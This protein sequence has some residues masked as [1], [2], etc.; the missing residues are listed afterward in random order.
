MEGDGRSLKVL[1][2]TQSQRASFLQILMRFG[3]EG[4]KLS[5]FELNQALLVI[6]LCLP[7]KAVDLC[8]ICVMSFLFGRSSTSSISCWI[9]IT[10]NI[11]F[12][13]IILAVG[14]SAFLDEQNF[15]SNVV[16]FRFPLPKAFCFQLF[17]LGICLL[18][19]PPSS[20]SLLN[21]SQKI[22]SLFLI[23]HC[24]LNFINV[25]Q[26]YHISLLHLWKT[27]ILNNLIVFTTWNPNWSTSLVLIASV[28]VGVVIQ[29]SF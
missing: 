19:I 1:D 24:S 4:N 13:I 21:C 23:F 3:T 28:V 20:F 22:Y 5:N 10:T 9:W 6:F 2:F 11:Y 16:Q 18:A 17:A 27:R 8:W 12:I 29:M 25:L 26:G 15:P 7:L 14:A